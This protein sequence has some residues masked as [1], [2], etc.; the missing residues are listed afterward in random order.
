MSTIPF[1]HRELKRA[2]CELSATA[3]PA[4][5]HR[6]NTHR[7]LL[8]YAVECGLKAVWLKRNSLTLF[9]QDDIDQF[10]HDIGKIFKCLHT[11]DEY[12]LPENL[13]LSPVITQ[14]KQKIP[15][16]GDISLLHQAWR[17]GGQCQQPSDQACEAQ[18][19]KIL[20]WIKKEL[21]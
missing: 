4:D 1:T 5:N 6:L 8:F 3:C 9:S 16:N 18:L 15:R 21:E 17:Y 7:L 10:G 14:D 20:K 19:E 11:G 2:W 12:S 13:Q